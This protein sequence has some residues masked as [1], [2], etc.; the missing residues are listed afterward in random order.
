MDEILTDLA[1][2]ALENKIS[3]M[4]TSKL[5][6]NTPSASDTEARSVVLN[7]NWHIKKQLAFQLAHEIAHIVNGDVS[8]QVLYFTPGKTG[9]ELEANRTAIKL[10]MPY[11]LRDRRADQVNPVEFM[12]I[13]AIPSHLASTVKSE[14][15]KA[16]Y[17][18]DA[19]LITD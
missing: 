5:G 14:L 19:E 6:P 3:F 4:A 17:S 18:R 13:F 16:C 11:Y 8:N 7:L 1:N 15:R 2:F 12:N 10:V 9:I